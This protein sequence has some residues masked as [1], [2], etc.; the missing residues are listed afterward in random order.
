MKRLIVGFFILV[1]RLVAA[2]IRTGNVMA[3]V[4]AG[5]LYVQI[6]TDIVTMEEKVGSALDTVACT[7][8]LQDHVGRAQAYASSC[9]EIASMEVYRA[10]TLERELDIWMADYDQLESRYKKEI[11]I[12]RSM[13]V[14]VER[15]HRLLRANN[16]KIPPQQTRPVG[17]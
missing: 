13:R 9:A 5:L 14:Y 6:Q 2:F 12:N 11:I 3:L 1:N 8:K 7:G 10:A 4:L 15:L 16:V 17:G